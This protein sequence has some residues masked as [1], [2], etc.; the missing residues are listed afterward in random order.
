MID[1]NNVNDPAL[2]VLIPAPE[3][4][5]ADEPLSP[6]EEDPVIT[7]SLRYWNSNSQCLSEW[8]PKELKKLAKVIG[9]AQSVTATDLKADQSLGWKMHSG[10]AKGSGFSRPSNLSKDIKLSEIRVDGKAR[11]HGALIDNIFFLVWLDRN[12]AVFPSKS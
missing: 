9:R 4:E 8:Q 6:K 11:I 1:D 12:H 5:P 3:P 7:I 10:P 2:D